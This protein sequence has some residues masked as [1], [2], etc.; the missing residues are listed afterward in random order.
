MGCESPTCFHVFSHWRHLPSTMAMTA[1]LLLSQQSQVYLSCEE[2]MFVIDTPRL[3]FSIG[4]KAWSVILLFSTRGDQASKHAKLAWLAHTLRHNNR[5]RHRAPRRAAA[6][7]SFAPKLASLSSVVSGRSM[8]RCTSDPVVL[9]SNSSGRPAASIK[10]PLVL[11]H[12]G[13]RLGQR[14][15]QGCCHS[16]ALRRIGTSATTP[17]NRRGCDA[18]PSCGVCVGVACRSEAYPRG[19]CYLKTIQVI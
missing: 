19:Q 6:S 1:T 14:R 15:P 11:P 12:Q 5:P 2:H 16:S 8:R 7:G 18:P 9:S 10:F 17:Q 3:S 13:G 4:M